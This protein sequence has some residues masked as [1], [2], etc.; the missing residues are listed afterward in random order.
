MTEHV[1]P[2]GDPPE[3]DPLAS[4]PFRAVRLL[5]RGAT[6]FV[7]EAEHRVLRTRVAVKVLRG[8]YVASP[9][10]VDRLRLEAQ[11]AASLGQSP[12]IVR[13][14]DFGRTAEGRPYLVMPKLDGRTLLDEIAVRGALPVDEAVRWVR[15]LL[16]GL[17]AA[18]AMGVIHR[19]IKPA[20]LFLSES[21]GGGERTLMILDFGIAKVLDDAD[22]EQAPAPLARPTHEGLTLGT[23]RWLA[24]EQALGLAQDRR[25][26]LYSVGVVA[27]YVLTGRDPFHHHTASLALLRAHAE[28]M[29]PPPSAVAS[30]PIPPALDTIVM[31]ALAKLP[32]DRFASAADFDAALARA[33]APGAGRWP[34][35]ERL[36]VRVF[37]EMVDA[38]HARA[39]GDSAV[40]E[41]DSAAETLPLRPMP[42]GTSRAAAGLVG[43]LQ[44]VRHARVVA[45]TL[46]ALGLILLLAAALRAL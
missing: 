4:T 46:A 21:R 41:R 2:E 33:I 36:D 11:A 45:G 30:Q 17:A 42:A 29:P 5:G 1:D 27:Y 19:D 38:Q 34:R 14:S 32:H 43:Q 8:D 7:Y 16:A 13:V 20:N 18:H 3:G 44:R 10:M 22:P 15:E 28:E 39:V 6:G 26:D 37:R 9:T 24:P 35:T 31:T 25:T 23:P 40:A 12:H